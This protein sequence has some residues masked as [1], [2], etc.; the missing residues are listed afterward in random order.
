LLSFA[1]AVPAETN[2]IG[3]D[4]RVELM[5]IVFRLAGAREYSQG[6]I[7][8]YT[9]AIDRYF[10][11]FRDHEA[12]RIARGLHDKDRATFD[13]VMSLAVHVKDAESLAEPVP[14]DRAGSL[15]K[16]WH[17][18]AARPFLEAARKFA[19][20]SDFAGFVKAQQP[21]YGRVDA[22]LHAYVANGADLAW[23]DRFCGQRAHAPF[24]LVPGLSNGGLSYGP[25]VTLANGAEE[26]YA[27][28][29]VWKVDADGLPV[30]DDEWTPML[31]HEIA[32]SYANPLID[33]FAAQMDPSDDRLFQA[34]RATMERQAYGNGHTV[35]CESLVRALTARYILE[36]QGQE[37]AAR[38][39]A[40]EQRRGFRW[41]GEL[42][43]LLGDYA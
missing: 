29:G 36:H 7:P 8:A 39:V 34:S 5:S 38:A 4:P 3:V 13:A 26:I 6:R 40:E 14:F 12:V 32:H 31:V 43:S 10:A 9:A 20:D 30:F 35:L 21:F 41:T 18:A 27:I 28:P 24:H 22:R 23:F 17:G 16:R 37:K 42:L 15:D 11:T 2:R 33:T 1:A 25:H 19:A